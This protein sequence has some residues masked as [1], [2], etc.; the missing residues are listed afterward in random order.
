MNLVAFAGK[1]IQRTSGTVAGQAW[2]AGWQRS[3]ARHLSF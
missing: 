2:R 3:G 1:A